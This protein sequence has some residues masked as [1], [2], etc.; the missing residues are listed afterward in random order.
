[1]YESHLYW[2]YLAAL[3][4]SNKQFEI[5]FKKIIVVSNMQRGIEMIV[6]ITGI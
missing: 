5:D 6:T 4:C 2:E 3:N 1:M